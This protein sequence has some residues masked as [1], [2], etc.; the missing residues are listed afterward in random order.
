MLCAGLVGSTGMSCIIVADWLPCFEQVSS[1]V[2]VYYVLLL[3]TGDHALCWFVSSACM[4]CSV[5]AVW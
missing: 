2:H 5:I 4:S 1:A 3:L